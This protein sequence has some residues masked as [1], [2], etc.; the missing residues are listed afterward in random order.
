MT[1]KESQNIEF[2]QS[3]RQDCLKVITAFANS[4]GGMLII[5]LD[6]NGNPVRLKNT[7]KMLEDIPNTIRHKT[8][9]IPSVK[10]SKEGTIKITI[11]SSSVPVSY[12]GKFYMRS[13]STV[14][15]LQGRELADFLLRKSGSTWDGTI[16]E[17]VKL[18][19]LDTSV[20][21]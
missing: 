5:G 20:Q 18:N 13:G 10:L 11:R 16:E 6:D 1:N 19:D 3:W 21:S 2:K 12:N 14:Q 7:K 15:E 4:N 8:G 17:S 9:I